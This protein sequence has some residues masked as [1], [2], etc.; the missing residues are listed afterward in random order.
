MA[1][2]NNTHRSPYAFDAYLPESSSTKRE[3]S[4]LMRAHH[5]ALGRFIVEMQ[6]VDAWLFTTMRVLTNVHPILLRIFFTANQRGSEFKERLKELIEAYD[7]PPD[8]VRLIAEALEKFAALNTMRNSLVHSLTVIGEG[9]E[10]I[11]TNI[12]LAKT[13]RHLKQFAIDP[14]MIDDMTFDLR[15]I[16]ARLTEFQHR[17]LD[18]RFPN[19]Q[20]EPKS[21]IARLKRELRR[22][23]RYKQP[24]P[25]N[26]H[27]RPR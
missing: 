3:N 19:R 15:L 12:P 11:I 24:S 27:R 23:W 7:L 13:R 17:V 14:K 5:K 6:F 1:S 26:R 8:D 20:K 16:H 10:I 25:S 18:R 21:V 9:P 2:K 22:S 4:A